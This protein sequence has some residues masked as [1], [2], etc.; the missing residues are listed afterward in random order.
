MWIEIAVLTTAALALAYW[1][2]EVPRARDGLGN[3]VRV[4]AGASAHGS[5]DRPQRHDRSGNAATARRHDRR[6]G[7]VGGDGTAHRR[8]VE[9][10]TTEA[11]NV[12]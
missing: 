2:R 8:A 12:V 9:H 3:R 1:T 6:L 7:G 4:D 11:H 10:T 5:R